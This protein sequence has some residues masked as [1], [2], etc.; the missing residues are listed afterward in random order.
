MRRYFFAKNVLRFIIPLL[1]P[2]IILGGFSIVT[3]LSYIR[4]ELNNSNYKMLEQTRSTIE[5]MFNELDSVHYT[6]NYNSRLILRLRSL[7]TGNEASSSDIEAF[8]HFMSIINAPTNIRP[9]IHS[10]YLYYDN[11]D[12]HFLAS[13][14]GRVSINSY[15]DVSWYTSLTGLKRLKQD[16]HIERRTMKRY[17]FDRKETELVTLYKRFVPPGLTK[18]E[19]YMV[20]NLWKEEL[21]HDMASLL[22]QPE[23]LVFIIDGN[24]EILATTNANHA[25]LQGIAL[26]DLSKS[27]RYKSVITG[28]SYVV[29]KLDSDSYD[30][31][32]ISVTPSR[33]FYQLSTNLLY[34]T[35]A[36]VIVSLILG[37]FLTYYISRR[38]HRNMMRVLLTIDNAEKGMPIPRLPEKVTDEYSFILQSMIKSFVERSSLKIQLTEKKYMLQMMELMALQSNINPHFMAN[39]LRTIF[40]KSIGLTGGQNEVSQM[41]DYLSEVVHYAISASNKK[42]TLG[43][44][45]RNTKHYI[46]IMKIRYKDKFHLIWDYDEELLDYRII[47]LLFQPLLENAIYHGIKE[48]NRFGYVK[49][50]IRRRGSKLLIAIIDTGL[51]MNRERL[52]QLRQMFTAEKETKHIGLYNTYKRLQIMYGGQ[53]QFRIRS[54]KG[55]GTVIEIILP[56]DEGIE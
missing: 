42:V 25:D 53:Q 5:L 14:E 52:V 41:L 17:A 33:H 20:S 9:H 34:L 24:K 21:E 18:T 36:L 50:R 3:T 29:S 46:E 40:W 1:I 22:Y 15:N 37:L 54:K 38:N 44:E 12:G 2:L 55:W 6:L 4:T 8:N 48:S 47:K 19:G 35:V 49:V 27:Q 31:Q 28:E 43:E 16:L 7:L 13:N 11:A 23:Q 30:L 45:L 10:I 26:L 51:G 56:L 39:T 32:Y